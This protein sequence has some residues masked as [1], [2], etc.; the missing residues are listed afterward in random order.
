M[1]V[2]DSLINGAS[3]WLDQVFE[4]MSDEEVDLTLKYNERTSKVFANVRNWKVPRLP[5]DGY[6]LLLAELV[7]TRST[8]DRGPKLFFDSGRRGVGAVIA[9]EERIV[10]TGYNGSPPGEP[11]CDRL[12]C[13][14][15]LCNWEYPTKTEEVGT[16]MNSE[17]PK[18]GMLLN[19]GHLLR[20]G[21]CVRSLHAEE[22][23]LLQCAIDGVSPRGGTVY[24]TA[25]PCWDCAKRLVRVGIERIV[26]GTEYESRHGMSGETRE[27]LI[28]AEISMTR[29]DLREIFEELYG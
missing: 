19:G 23:A 8:C 1:S 5:W 16:V 18:C 12:E 28:R 4:A 7:A 14:N 20:N 27:L 21:H 29:I 24:T 3:V 6:F 26:Y 22:N 15:T 10:A 25:F 11:H 13:P 2:R 17:C 9:V